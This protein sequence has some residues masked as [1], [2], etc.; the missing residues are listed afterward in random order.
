[1]LR[2][3]VVTIA[4]GL[5]TTG[6]MLAASAVPAA[7]K[8]T[9]TPILT[10][11]PSS[12]A[13]GIGG[14]ISDTVTV[15]GINNPTGKIIFTLFPPA[16]A[17]QCV[18]LKK[19]I[20][21]ST[22]SLVDGSATSGTYTVTNQYGYGTYT[23][24]AYYTG[25][26]N[27]ASNS[28]TCTAGRLVV[29]RADPTI[30]TNQSGT[31]PAGGN[32]SD[33][34][35]LS[36]ADHPTGTF[37]F[38]LY[39]SEASCGGSAYIDTVTVPVG[40]GSNSS[41]NF[42]APTAGTYDWYVIYS[43]DSNNESAISYCDEPITVTLASPTITTNPS[44]A[45]T[46]G[47]TIKDVA[48]V[49][50]GSNPTGTVSFEL[51]GPGDTTCSTEIGTPDVENLSNAGKATSTTFATA[52]AGTYHWIA[53]YSGDA[54]NNGV[55][56]PCGEAVPVNKA[57]P[58]IVTTTES[59]TQ[60]L[61]TTGDD[62]ATVT[63]GDSPTGSVTFYL[64][65]PGSTC[66]NSGVG[67]G[68]SSGP[69]TLSGGTATSAALS[70]TIAGTYKWVAIYSGDANNASVT[71]GCNEEHVTVAQDLPTIGTTVSSGKAIIGGTGTDTATV[72]GGDSPTGTV[73]FYLFSPGTCPATG[74]SGFIDAEMV[75]LSGG[76]ATTGAE[77][78]SA[79][80]GTYEWLAIYS[81]DTN[82]AGV[83]TACGDEPV[84]VAK[85]TPT[86]VTGCQI[87]EGTGL[88]SGDLLAGCDSGPDTATVSGSSGTPTGT[89][90]F[91]A[92][93]DDTCSGTPAIAAQTVTL[94]GGSA[95]S[96]SV[97]GTADEDYFWLVSYSGDGT[98]NSTTST[99][100]DAVGDEETF[101]PPA[102]Q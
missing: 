49:H 20:F 42:T 10:N 36:G 23:W 40:V 100:G 34:A 85:P 92:Y 87:T 17:G 74:T 77:T 82:N 31:V 69:I 59:P 61:G 8:A 18:N 73:T 95:S 102:I 27:N 55:T 83:G 29:T 67:A 53:T 19:P 30:S 70:F 62:V 25:D 68:Q 96:A 43:G 13:V 94:V 44:N 76:S 41:G 90:T 1:M 14:K 39:S 58:T 51:F 21:T 37:T 91:T 32:V 5:L 97:P 99:C 38:Y 86:L 22:V 63:G 72:S 60:A 81:G 98:Y 46:V 79:G 65:S 56:S 78:F 9:P 7:A 4:A 24:I 12:G 80:A 47:G 28:T 16:D 93:P 48:T 66:A 6:V 54:N 84:T 89:V 26:K 33:S 88:E 50:G 3:V 75:P 71:S 57:T 15:T 35:T 101:V 52:T 11:T 45:V 64:Y 2:S